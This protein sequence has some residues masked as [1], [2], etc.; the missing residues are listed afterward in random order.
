MVLQVYN[1]LL[2]RTMET[3]NKQTLLTFYEQMFDCIFGSA[4]ETRIT[5]ADLKHTNKFNYLGKK[6]TNKSNVKCSLV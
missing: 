3:K 6:I 5:T 1:Y 2:C 4:N